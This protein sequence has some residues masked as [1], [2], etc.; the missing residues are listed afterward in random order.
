MILFTLLQITL[1]YPDILRKSTGYVLQEFGKGGG[2]LIA[3]W[4]GFMLTSILFAPLV[5][6]VHSILAREE[7]GYLNCHGPRRDCRRFSDL[8]S[9]CGRWY[10]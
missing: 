9:I 7:T 6:M 5:V 8:Q 2:A 10:R 4:Y 3:I 1:E